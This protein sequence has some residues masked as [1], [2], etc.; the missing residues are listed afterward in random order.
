MHG[1][2]SSELVLRCF[3]FALPQST[4][5]KVSKEIPANG[6]LRGHGAGGAKKKSSGSAEGRDFEVQVL[7]RTTNIV[8]TVLLFMSACSNVV[9]WFQLDNWR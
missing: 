4:T 9:T 2:T 5:V 7:L 6:N 1:V 8:Q 3:S